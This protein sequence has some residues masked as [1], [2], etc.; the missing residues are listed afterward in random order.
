M[1]LIKKA[2][3]PAKGNVRRVLCVLKAESFARFVGDHRTSDRF[4]AD[5]GC[6]RLFHPDSA[7]KRCM[8]LTSAECT[9]ENS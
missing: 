8:K 2:A 6:S 3:V 9:V 5:S 1:G 4:H 7:W